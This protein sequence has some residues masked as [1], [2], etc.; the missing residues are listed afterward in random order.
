[1]EYCTVIL[2]FIALHVSVYVPAAQALVLTC[3]AGV[4]W[5]SYQSTR[6]SNDPISVG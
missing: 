6:K 1:M 2:F 5:L 4:G 3:E